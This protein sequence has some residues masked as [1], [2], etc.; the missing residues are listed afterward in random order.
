MADPAG[1]GEDPAAQPLLIVQAVA[2]LPGE[3]GRGRKH[4]EYD[5]RCATLHLLALLTV[6]LA[7]LPVEPSQGKG[8]V[9]NQPTECR[10]GFPAGKYR[11]SG[12]SHAGKCLMIPAG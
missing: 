8:L 2:G 11:E 7:T 10:A 5:D 12:V 3:C 9:R 4:Q 1:L 6:L